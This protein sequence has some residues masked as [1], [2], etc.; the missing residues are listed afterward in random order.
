MVV[1][2]TKP[3][4]FQL[5]EIRDLFRRALSDGAKDPE[6][7]IDKL[8]WAVD[9][10]PGLRIWVGLERGMPKSILVVYLPNDPQTDW[11]MWDL[12]AHTGS[13]DLKKAMITHGVAFLK[14]AGYN[15]AWAFNFSGHSDEAYIRSARALGLQVE[16]RSTMMTVRF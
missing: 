12:A 15:Q 14:E 4:I 13:V 6:R 9:K 11:P 8:A 16:K 3:D 7:S 1:R 5:K 2:V 10:N